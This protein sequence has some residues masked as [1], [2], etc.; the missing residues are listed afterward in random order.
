MN[1][2]ALA[3]GT[4]VN[5]A[6]GIAFD[7]CY[8]KLGKAMFGKKKGKKVAKM[9]T[10]LSVM[11]MSYITSNVIYGMGTTE[12]VVS[13]DDEGNYG[14]ETSEITGTAEGDHTPNA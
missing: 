4:I 14:D 5:V 10:T 6:G 7:Q 1:L 9:A 8:Q 2:L 11:G 13:N 3:A 12:E